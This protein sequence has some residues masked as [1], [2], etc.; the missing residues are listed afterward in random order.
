MAKREEAPITTLAELRDLVT[1]DDKE[2]ASFIGRILDREP[3]EWI[4]VF[5]SQDKPDGKA[6]L[7]ACL[8][9]PD[10]AADALRQPGWELDTGDGAP[11]FTVHYGGGKQQAEYLTSG[12]EGVIPVVY[13]RTFEGGVFPDVVEMAEDFRLFWELFH[14]EK[15][16]RWLAADGDGGTVVVAVQTATTLRIRKTF[17]RRYQAARQLY[18]SQQFN[19]IRRGGEEL[20]TAA[21]VNMEVGEGETRIAYYGGPAASGQDGISYFTRCFGKHVL[22]PPPIEQCGVWP[23]EPSRSYTSFIIGTDDDGNAIEYVCDPA[24]LSDYFGGNPG[25]PHFL[26]PVLFERTVLEKYYADPDR[27]HVDDGYIRVTG[28]WSM[29]I[30]NALD[31]YIAVFLGDLGRLPDREQ[32]Y[33]RSFNVPSVGRLSETAIRRSIFGEFADTDRIEYRFSRAYAAV[34]EAWERRFGWPLFKDLNPGDDHLA[35]SLHVPTNRGFAA[36]DPQL[37]GLAKLVV[38]SLNEEELGKHV[39]G[40]VAEEKGIGKLDRFLQEQGLSTGSALCATLRQVQGARSKSSAH[41]KRSDFDQAL[42]LD[43]A[44]SL[45]ARFEG[46]LSSLATSFEQLSAELKEQTASA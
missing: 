6:F 11:G 12:A 4:T 16:G 7:L 39:T 3:G 41:R 13:Y 27:Y 33:W 23:F 32:R 35:H 46:L 21:E 31:E 34:N 42:L 37:V 20:R 40:K 22:P 1:R 26:T 15:G 14:E 44:D 43:G 24:V 25:A 17:L 8:L 28:G 19:I 2:L 36:F 5:E 38:D 10:V 29:P 45:P 30:D 18:L 9:T